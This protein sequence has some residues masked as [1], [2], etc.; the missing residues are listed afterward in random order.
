MNQSTRL[1][2]GCSSADTAFSSSVSADWYQRQQV[3][4]KS[5]P[6]QFGP[7][8]GSLKQGVASS[9]DKLFGTFHDKYRSPNAT[10]GCYILFCALG[11]CK[12]CFGGEHAQTSRPPHSLLMYAEACDSLGGACNTIQSRQRSLALMTSQVP[13]TAKLPRERERARKGVHFCSTSK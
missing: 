12:S 7:C 9:R 5:A 3:L 10:E 6:G 8:S 2:C 4:E 1:L 11:N 13:Q